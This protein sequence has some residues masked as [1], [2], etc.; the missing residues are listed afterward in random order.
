MKTWFCILSIAWALIAAGCVST[1]Q[2]RVEAQPERFNS[3]STE[4]QELILQGKIDIGFDEDMVFMAAGVPDKK[5]R[6]TSEKG[7]TE[8]WTYYNYVSHPIMFS[9]GWTWN[10]FFYYDHGGS[11]WIRRGYSPSIYVSSHDSSKEINLKV[12]FQDG[13]VIAFETTNP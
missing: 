12:E 8:V 11:R 7:I 4:A 3:Y 1:P 13:K 9:S 6:R 2:S 10:R 5:A